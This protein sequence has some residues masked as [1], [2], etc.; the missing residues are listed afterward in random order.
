MAVRFNLARRK[1][2]ELLSRAE[3]TEPPVP[4]KEL[5]RSAGGDIRYEPFR[6]ELSGMRL[7]QPGGSVIGV[8]ALHPPVRQRFTIAHEIGHLLLHPRDNFHLDKFSPI[9]FRNQRSSTGEDETEIE[10]NQFAAELL[11]P[12]DMVRREVAPLLGRSAED[13]IENLARK[14]QVSVQ[15]MTI[16]L[17]TMGLLR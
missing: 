10:A 15:A 5:A 14:F 12:E 9:Q 6:G 1:A 7:A 17:T 13:A 11:M 16:R 3:V 2:R 8:N 4:V